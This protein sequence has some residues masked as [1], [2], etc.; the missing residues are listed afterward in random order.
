MAMHVDRK[1]RLGGVQGDDDKLELGRRGC[2]WCG[3]LR[4]ACTIVSWPVRQLSIH[5]IKVCIVWS[6]RGSRCMHGVRTSR[7]KGQLHRMRSDSIASLWGFRYIPS[8]YV[9]TSGQ[10]GAFDGRRVRFTHSGEESA[11]KIPPRSGAFETY[12]QRLPSID[13][14]DLTWN[15]KALV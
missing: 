2:E 6:G 1:R 15:R 10:G 14:V 5:T 13:G 11:Y 8:T 3:A 9:S 7:S 12:R 4:T